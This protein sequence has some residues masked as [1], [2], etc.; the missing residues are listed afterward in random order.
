V[1]EY[2]SASATKKEEIVEQATEEQAEERHE[3]ANELWQEGEALQQALDESCGSTA[4]ADVCDTVE[5][6]SRQFEVR[7][8]AYAV[9]SIVGEPDMDDEPL[10]NVM[11]AFE[12]KNDARDYLRNTV[13]MEQVVT[14]CYVVAMY[15]WIAPVLVFTKK[16]FE[17]VESNYTHTQLEEIHHGKRAERK[18]IEK[19][20]ASRGKTMA[21]VDAF[22][23]DLEDEQHTSLEEG[24]AET[25]E[26]EPTAIQEDAATNPAAVKAEV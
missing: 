19:L 1:E 18:K 16:F 2:I 14:N 10:I 12:S 26:G 22:M 3:R 6:V 25:E 5:A 20:L 8:Q 23:N 24:G 13:H 21:D 11:C 17:E 15:E 4:D 9:V 7:G